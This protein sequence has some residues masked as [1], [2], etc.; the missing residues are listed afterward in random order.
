MNMSQESSLKII[1]H[2]QDLFEWCLR[3]A[4]ESIK[5]NHY[6]KAARWCE[7]ASI[8]GDVGE[9]GTLASDELENLL[10]AL[11]KQVPVSPPHQIQPLDSNKERWLHVLTKAYPVGG[12]TALVKC[13]IKSDSDNASHSVVLTDQLTLRA[14][15]LQQAVSNSGGGVHSIAEKHSPLLRAAALR[16]LAHD[17]NVVVLH[18]HMDDIVPALAFGVPSK[19]PVLLLNHAD[20][21]FWVGNSAVDMALNI[22]PASEYLTKKYRGIKNSYLL[23]IPL[24]E[25]H[26][27]GPNKIDKTILRKQTRQKLGIPKDSRVLLTIGTAHKYDPVRNL[28]F[29]QTALEIVHRIPNTYIIAVGPSKNN[30]IW[31][32]AFTNSNGRII[33]VGIQQDLEPFHAIADVYGEGFPFGS[34]TALLEAGLSGLPCILAPITASPIFLSSDLSTQELDQPQDTGEYADM[35][36]TLLE[37]SQSRLSH[38][39]A[40][41]AKKVKQYHCEAEWANQLTSLRNKIPKE[42]RTTPIKDIPNLPLEYI[43]HALKLTP[44]H[45]RKELRSL[46]EERAKLFQL[47]LPNPYGLCI[48]GNNISTPCS[49]FKAIKLKIHQKTSAAKELIKNKSSRIK[50]P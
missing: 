43:E 21:T 42:H 5:N 49:F 25:I 1:K 12:H 28:D 22:R 23:P 16:D 44:R 26:S 3:G 36:C 20:H 6:I 10:I 8:V 27:S 9:I 47:T 11:S 4:K 48:D 45:D 32:E 50:R 31:A 7:S 18:I 29:Q 41:M 33:S 24:E 17:V 35:A 13:W 38:L 46:I 34:L 15:N 30:P 39:G 19:T 14:P 40:T 37:M 2:H